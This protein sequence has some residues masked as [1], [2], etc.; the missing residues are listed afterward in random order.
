M[1]NFIAAALIF[2]VNLFIAKNKLCKSSDTTSGYIIKTRAVGS[3]ANPSA[4]FAWIN[5]AVKSITYFSIDLY[6]EK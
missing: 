5:S 3:D 4:C 1:K 2:L 6:Q